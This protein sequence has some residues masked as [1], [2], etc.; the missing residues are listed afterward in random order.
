MARQQKEYQKDLYSQDKVNIPHD[1]EAEK[2][3][4]GM[5]IRD[6]NNIDYIDFLR[7]DHFYYPV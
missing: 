6:N 4:L 2:E 7:S 3:L 5:L 1:L